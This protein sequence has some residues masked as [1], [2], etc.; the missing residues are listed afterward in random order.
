MALEMPVSDLSRARVSEPGLSWPD[1]VR[2]VAQWTLPTGKRKSTQIILS[3]DEYFGLGQFGAP[4]NGERLMQKI[5]TLR[6]QKP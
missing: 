1:E 2:I 4:M 5:E 6:R 3:K